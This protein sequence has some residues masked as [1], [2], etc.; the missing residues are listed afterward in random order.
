MKEP[1]FANGSDKVTGD[2]LPAH[3]SR[4]RNW[5]HEALS[6]SKEHRF[7]LYEGL[8]RRYCVADCS[9]HQPDAAFYIASSTLADMS[10]NSYHNHQ[11]MLCPLQNEGLSLRPPTRP[12]LHQLVAFYV[13][14]LFLFRFHILLSAYLAL[15][16]LSRPSFGWMIDCLTF[17]LSNLPMSTS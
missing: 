1:A 17:S 3:P 16:P 2:F 6:Y 15:L 9:T 10:I 7:I 14:I 8:L 13:C 11:P 12:D 5:A 4:T